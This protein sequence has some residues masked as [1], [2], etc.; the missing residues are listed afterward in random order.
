MGYRL[1][2]GEQGVGLRAACILLTNARQ[3]IHQPVSNEIGFFHSKTGGDIH[4]QNPYL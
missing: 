1:C 4:D 3:S 2:I